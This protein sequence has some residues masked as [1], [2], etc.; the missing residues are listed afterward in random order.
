MR[1]IAG[2]MVLFTVFLALAGDTGAGSGDSRDPLRACVYDNVPL[3]FFDRSGN[4][5]G[6]FI[7]IL[8]DVARKEGWKLEYR[9]ASWPDC[10]NSLETGASDILPVIAY[11][12]QR[13]QRYEFSNETVV[14]NYGV[15]FAQR[16]EHI[17]SLLDLKDKTVGVLRGDIYYEALQKLLAGF[18][19]D[20][21]Y[22]ERDS[23]EAIQDLL[24]IREIEAGLFS[25]IYSNK[26]KFPSSI[27]QTPIVLN[28]LEVRFAAPKGQRRYLDAIDGYL[29]AMKTD[30]DST[31]H[32]SMDRWLIV[33]HI[34]V[35]PR[36]IGW[37]AGGLAAAGVAVFLFVFLLR[38]EV[39]AKTGEIKQQND[40]LVAEV[41]RRNEAEGRLEENRKR[42]QAILES[43]PMVLWTL[44][45]KGIITFAE[46]KSL[47]AM[48]LEA[49]RITGRSVFDL[50]ADN[51]Q[52]VEN[53]RRT[54]NGETFD[55]VVELKG[56]FYE[57]RSVPD[58]DEA[59]APAGT[60]GVA[61]DVT[62]RALAQ[63]R[64][65]E[66]ELRFRSAFRTNP[67][68]ININ[69]F[70]DGLY[71]DVN[72]GFTGLT[73]YSRDEVIGRSSLDIDI[74]YDPADREQLVRELLRSSQVANLE[75]RFRL[76][77]GRVQ[78][79]LMS[80]SLIHL[81][82]EPHILSVT[83]NIE[84]RK[85]MEQ[86]L[87]ESEERF[88]LAFNH[89]MV[90]KAIV[91][92]EG[93]FLQANSAFLDILGMTAD[94]LSSKVWQDTI[95][96][97]FLEQTEESIRDLVDGRIPAMHLELKMLRKD[98]QGV[99][100][101]VF[102]VLVRDAKGNPLY[103]VGDVEDITMRHEYE[104]QLRK[105]ERIVGTSQDQMSLVNVD[106]CYEAVN[107]S[108]LKAHG[109]SR[110]EI[111]GHSVAE[112]N[113]EAAFEETI[114]SHLDKAF[115]GQIV[116]YQHEFDF[117]GIGKRYMD[118]SYFPYID[119][120]GRTTG[121]VV[122]ARDVTDTRMAEHRLLQSQKMEA[123]GALAGGI[124]HDFNN[125]L[126]PI[127][128]YSEMLL[129]DLPKGSESHG[130]AE[131]IR[132]AGI[133]VG[134]LVRQILTFSRISNAETKPLKV[135]AILKEV[136]TLVRSTIPA[137]IEISQTIDP[138]CGMVMADPTQVHQVAM[139]LITNAYHAMADGGKMDIRLE[140][141]VL[142]AHQLTDAATAPGDFV[143]LTV[144]DSGHGM[145][146]ETMSRIFEPYFT[147]KERGK[148]TGLGLSVVLGIVK[149]FG[150][151]VK[152]HSEVGAGSVFTVCFPAIAPVSDTYPPADEQP[153]SGGSE[154]ILLVDDE[155][156][157]VAMEQ[158]M[159]ERLGYVVSIS[160]GSVE[161]LDG[162]RSAPDKFDLVITDMTM[163]RMTG[164]Q[165]S[166]E[167]KKIRQDVKV[168]LCTGFSEQI[169]QESVGSLN[170]DGFLM[171][172]VTMSE[173]STLVRTVL[174]D[175]NSD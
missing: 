20:C 33:Q 171:K 75:A 159:L 40:R 10:L 83:R 79:G 61:V 14:T 170:I 23:Y 134:E 97:D 2:F 29:S 152:V 103:L 26:L 98:G 70:S 38:R 105:Y 94:A 110:D 128:G 174:S 163:P 62:D 124:A 100:A 137:T 5:R 51:P 155:A 92:P 106:Y 154:R 131:R 129:E 148:G 27:I 65:A 158:A 112:V 73:G 8:N 35:F 80:A 57:T 31:F 136:L 30:P 15:V 44:D 173:L 90:G 167:L 78:T 54:L 117:R 175:G 125:I 99:W 77:D 119:E 47:A 71:L 127:I 96:P 107:D 16:G 3:G 25:R 4:P 111:V 135:Q 120:D 9:Q 165:L 133:R 151:E 41:G 6:L 95:H 139:N 11:S 36:W 121:V 86:E 42:F 68:S 12:E 49:G 115:S 132:T 164:L 161:A 144:E 43:A 166:R 59:G 63:R 58:T 1:I 156:Q 123:I 109:R 55:A 168:I 138:K 17:N 21:R 145:D 53:F 160:T 34:H 74:W 104:S 28:P 13:A 146:K 37:V 67:D 66:S 102:Y 162:F 72:D 60:I 24:R 114:K 91:L 22:V 56:R 147:T 46:G 7:D 116:S 172:P 149:K 50:Y 113:G 122:H 153:L 169:N 69:R 39:Y 108:Y 143:C 52:I 150:G 76:K 88:R 142:E 81:N 87:R 19:V 141:M 32:R 101:R 157:I 85:R 126:S 84:E 140:N 93:P 64:L 18:Q 89:A 118:V 48:G 130:N 82:G 45:R